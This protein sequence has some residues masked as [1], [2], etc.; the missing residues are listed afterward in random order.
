MNKF[1]PDQF[2]E[3][4]PRGEYRGGESPHSPQGGG[5]PQPRYVDIIVTCILYI[6]MYL[7]IYMY[8]YIY[9][10]GVPIHHKEVDILNRGM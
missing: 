7:F 4:S 9:G 8:M 3:G 10:G 5:Y 6:E 1:A 2:Q